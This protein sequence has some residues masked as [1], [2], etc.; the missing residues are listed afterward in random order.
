TN[1]NQGGATMVVR[2][3]PD[4]KRIA[5]GGHDK[6]VRV[7]DAAN[8][9]ELKQF[10]GHQ[11]SVLHLDWSADGERLVVA[12]ISE[13]PHL[14]NATTGEEVAL[15]KG[16]TK[17]IAAVAFSADGRILFTGSADGTLRAWDGFT[18]KAGRVVEAEH[19]PISALACAPDGKTVVTGHDDG[20]IS[21]RDAD[22]RAELRSWK[23]PPSGVKS[24]AFSKDGTSLVTTSVWSC[25]PRIWDFA[26]GKSS[27]F[28][29]EHICPMEWLQASA[30]G[31]QL[32]A[33]D[34][35]RIALKWDVETGRSERWFTIADTPFWR[36]R[37]APDRKTLA[38]TAFRTGPV[39][40]WDVNSGK[41]LRTLQMTAG[42]F[43]A[44]FPVD[45]SPDNKHL[46]A[47]DGDGKVVIW[48]W[49][50]GTKVREFPGPDSPA[51]VTY[52]ADGSL[53][54]VGS[55]EKSASTL[56]VWN[57]TT[58]KELG[59]IPCDTPMFAVY[60]SPDGQWLA[61]GGEY[62]QPVRLW[63]LATLREGPALL[64]QAERGA[65]AYGFSSDGRFL[66][67]GVEADATLVWDVLT[68][69]LLRQ[70]AGHACGITAACF[71]IDG[72]TLFTGGSDSTI[73]RW[74]LRHGLLA[75]ESTAAARQQWWNELSDP[76]AENALRAVWNL[77]TTPAETAALAAAN[78]KP[79]A[80][81]SDEQ[82]QQV[83]RWLADL[84]SPK[85]A[86]RNAAE[87]ELD[88]IGEP[89]LPML[90]AAKLESPE[91]RRRIDSLLA[92]RTGSIPGPAS[93]RELRAVQV[94]E[95][96]GGAG[97]RKVL[98]E[99]SGGLPEARLT[100]EA[101]QALKRVK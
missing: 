99:L 33:V 44:P 82:A 96:A 95:Y 85:F 84:E 73:L 4:G 80:P 24:I 67:G 94:L 78:L 36:L 50:A 26:T 61:T 75:K 16:H 7:W 51:C 49:T 83:K 90:R 89:L 32:L 68:G 41:L 64:G 29:D 38:L 60:L 91:G 81:L 21:V 10:T 65:Y 1:G 17:A 63:S 28:W 18:G 48:D 76:D 25:G 3:S 14:W 93:R 57:V 6:T 59:P 77:A 42:K 72:H 35:A 39:K 12:G 30:D 52:S 62:A 31:K 9:K 34:R 23:L 45:F 43:S 86:V 66:V 2:F 27:P 47:I 15:L 37:F 101:Q 13:L 92:K 46:A 87:A 8:G 5:T 56:R 88:R 58:G 11:N 69:Q 22:G 40:L 20:T 55:M 97:C 74:D 19:G 70:Y 53:L 79:V 98:D 71:G 54:A 100:Q